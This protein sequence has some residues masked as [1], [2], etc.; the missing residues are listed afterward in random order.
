LKLLT[1]KLYEKQ[2]E[3]RQSKLKGLVGEKKEIAWGSQI[4]SYVFQPYTLVKDA[5]TKY[6]QGNIQAVMDGDL[7]GFV[8]AYLKEFGADEHGA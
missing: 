8:N 1:A 3:E 2:I 7:D 4:R 5:R 6:E